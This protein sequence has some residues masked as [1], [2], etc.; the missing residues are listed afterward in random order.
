MRAVIWHTVFPVLNREWPTV[1]IKIGASKKPL[2]RWINPPFLSCPSHI[3]TE[4][5][6][7]SQNT[8]QCQTAVRED[9]VGGERIQQSPVQ[10]ICDA[11]VK[12]SDKRYI[13]CL[14]P[15]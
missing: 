14:F 11:L 9:H 15:R 10:R 3:L 13:F 6:G 4:S 12:S 2:Q 1:M 5:W 8:S 7:L